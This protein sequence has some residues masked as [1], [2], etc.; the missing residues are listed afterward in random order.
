MMNQERQERHLRLFTVK[1][2]KEL[3]DDSDS[4]ERTQKANVPAQMYKF[5]F[6][7]ITEVRLQINNQSFSSL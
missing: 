4:D 2:K 1:L 6:E 7:Y 3:V 5:R